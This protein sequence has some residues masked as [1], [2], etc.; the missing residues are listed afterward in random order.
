MYMFTLFPSMQIPPQLLLLSLF[1]VPLPPLKSLSLL[2]HLVSVTS[3][4]DK[5]IQ[6]QRNTH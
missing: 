4:K 3:Q 6:Q 2:L 1:P 5:A